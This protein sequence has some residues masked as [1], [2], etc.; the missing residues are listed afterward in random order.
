MPFISSGSMLTVV[1]HGTLYVSKRIREDRWSDF[2]TV[3]QKARN[4]E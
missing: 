1:S 2:T 3:I 4:W